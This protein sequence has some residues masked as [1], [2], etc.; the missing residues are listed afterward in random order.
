MV[1]SCSLCGKQVMR[2]SG[3][4]SKIVCHECRK[5]CRGCPIRKRYVSPSKRSSCSLCGKLVERASTSAEVQMCLPC[6]RTTSKDRRRDRQRAWQSE[7]AHKRRT[8]CVGCGEP[9]RGSRCDPCYRS[10]QSEHWVKYRGGAES[11]RV[12]INRRRVSR[13][14][15][16]PGPWSESRRRT[17]L[18]PRWKAQGRMCAY[19]GASPVETV[20]HVMPLALGGTNYEGNLTPACRRCNSRKNNKLLA[21]WRYGTRVGGGSNGAQDA[22]EGRHRLG[23]TA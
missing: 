12:G 8:P 19:C 4:A 20:D 9:S 1:D 10:L 23:Q 17:V 3:S 7:N 18:L 15:S 11:R 13:D 2:T 5:A 22:T 6:R 21:V 14:T 16:A